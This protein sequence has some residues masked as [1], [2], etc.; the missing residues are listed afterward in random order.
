M[1]D[2]QDVAA[3]FWAQILGCTISKEPPAPDTPL[4]RLQAFA[5]EYG[6]ETLTA[7]HVRAAIEGRPLLPRDGRTPQTSA[8]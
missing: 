1:N 5:A 8:S 4:G 2:P 7:E 3:E 6:D